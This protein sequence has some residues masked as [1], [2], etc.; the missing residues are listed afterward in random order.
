MCHAVR[1]VATEIRAGGG[2]MRVG[3]VGVGWGWVGGG[4]RVVAHRRGGWVKKEMG[5]VVMRR[6]Q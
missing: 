6:G 4:E 1:M 5:V 2:D 3:K